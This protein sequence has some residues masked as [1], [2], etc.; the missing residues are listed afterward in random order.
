MKTTGALFGGALASPLTTSLSAP[1]G[2]TGAEIGLSPLDS[3]PLRFAAEEIRRAA[4]FAGVP[5]PEVT[6][7]VDG[8]GPAQGY[9]I[10]R[11]ERGGWVKIVGGGPAG[12]MYGGLDVATAIGLGALADL[13]PGA[14]KPHIE[15]RGI[16]FNIPLDLR[17]P[18]YSDNSDAAQANI[19]EMWSREFWREFFDEMARHR[20]NVLSLWSLH[21]FPSIVKVPEY[22]DVA[23]DDVLRARAGAFD[24]TY[25]HSGRDMFRPE[26]LDGA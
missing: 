17:T 3:P 10:E 7:E 8:R 2:R 18:S 4:Q 25:A 15:E 6:I 22:P 16:K 14:R 24:E 9:R 1:S 12:A 26:L 23:L 19:P 11:A 20:F 21:P 5:Q 13:K